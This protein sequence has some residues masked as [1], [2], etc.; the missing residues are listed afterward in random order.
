MPKETELFMDLDPRQPAQAAHSTEK[1]ALG[2]A[3]TLDSLARAVQGP[4]AKTGAQLA[5]SQAAL[6]QGYRQLAAAAKNQI[7]GFDELHLLKAQAQKP[8]PKPKA[9]GGGKK[10]SSGQKG[11]QI[12][13]EIINITLMGDALS[14]LAALARA[15]AEKALPSLCAGAGALGRALTGLMQTLAE[16]W[17]VSLAPLWQR[18]QEIFAGT[19]SQLQGLWQGLLYP[20]LQ[21]ILQMLTPGI[22][23][24]AQLCFALLQS[25]YTLYT[26]VTCGFIT[27]LEG[28][29]QFVSGVFAGAWAQ[30]WGGVQRIFDGVWQTIL[31]TVRGGVNG[32]IHLLN[33]LIRAAVGAVNTVI[34]GINRMGFTVPE[35][36]P[37]IG[38]RSFSPGLSYLSAYQL[39]KL[40]KG[41][42]LPANRPFLA[43]VGDQKQGTNV[44]AP[45]ETIQQALTQALQSSSGSLSA[46]LPLVVNLDGEALYKALHQVQLRRGAGIGGSFAD[47][48]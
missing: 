8:A 15:V 44:E 35:W 32:C 25:F 23:N 19:K 29:L 21:F 42:V 9:P 34:G 28:L 27:A 16:L 40:A 13:L 31:G 7:A 39:P 10:G 47:Y 22:R 2:F 17:Q 4:L 6:A 1:A 38:G 3:Q 37:G 41:A 11:S 26:D 48:Y 14:R 45:L 18:L 24:F 30:A 5:K 12:K 20:L 43:L 36:V 46:Q 33:S